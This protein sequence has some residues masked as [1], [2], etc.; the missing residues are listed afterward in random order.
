MPAASG[1]RPAEPLVASD[2][3]TTPSGASPGDEFWRRPPD[4][5]PTDGTSQPTAGQV[6]A[7]AGGPMAGPGPGAAGAGAGP[8]G[9]TG[10]PPTVP[11]PPGWRPPVHVQ[12]PPPRQ[13][14]PQD[15]AG[16]DSA[17]QQA[18]RLTYGVGVVAAV[19]LVLLV[20]LLCSRVIF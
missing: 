14:P 1:G 5:P 19:V 15:M 2:G 11:P 3:V 9:Y 6:G 12:V 13:L 4:Q 10:P 16:M 18:Q 17:E 20:C 7:G 8:G